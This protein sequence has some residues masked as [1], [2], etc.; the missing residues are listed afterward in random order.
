M[1]MPSVQLP[2]AE[3]WSM[4]DAMAKEKDAFGF[5]FSA[6]P[7][8]RYSALTESLRA[9]TYGELAAST[10][11]APGERR[12]A[13]MAVMVESAKPRTSQ[14]GNRYLMLTLSDRSGQFPA[15]CFDDGA[16]EA[17]IAMAESGGCGLIQVECDWREGE[18]APRI[19]VRSVQSLD[20]LVETT[21]LRLTVTIDR[22]APLHD[23]ARL[24]RTGGQ[25]KG[26]AMLF[27]APEEGGDPLAI[28]RL[29]RGFAIDQELVHRIERMGGVTAVALTLS[30]GMAQAA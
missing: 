28:M 2:R 3:P 18:D 21:P 8:S 11:A 27:I 12:P 25:G 10:P 30:G 22:A 16:T 14:R 1:T 5:Y 4:A 15:S 26:E 9:R 19:A 7:V 23:L 17:L 24:L 13:T 29:G 6:H 20:R